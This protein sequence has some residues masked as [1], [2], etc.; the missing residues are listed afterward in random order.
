[1]NEQAQKVLIDLLNRA[2]SG[3]DKAVEF[4]QAQ[5]PDVIHQLLVWNFTQSIVMAVIAMASI[6]PA[7][8]FTIMQFRRDRE[9]SGRGYK[10]TLVFDSDG[11][12]HPL[13]LLFFLGV[14]IYAIFVI[15]AILDLAWL[16]IWLAPK[17]YL[18][19]YAATLIK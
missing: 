16:K 15:C 8:R 9:E 7:Y 2:V 11:D 19:E 5:I 6:Y 13:S 3:I 10:V 14:A 12:I 4:S 18:L 1:M 17:L